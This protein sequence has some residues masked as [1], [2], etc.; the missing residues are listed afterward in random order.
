[1]RQK[2]FKLLEPS[3]DASST[4][5]GMVTQHIKPNRGFVR[6]GDATCPFRI[7]V[8]TRED[9]RAWPFLVMRLSKKKHF[10]KAFNIY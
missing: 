3:R 9:E 8:Y 6:C 1:M 10:V 5:D 2:H 7:R 4:V